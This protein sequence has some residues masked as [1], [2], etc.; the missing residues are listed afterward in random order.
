[1][2]HLTKAAVGSIV[3]RASLLTI[4]YLAAREVPYFTAIMLALFVIGWI[5]ERVELDQWH[6][7][8]TEKEQADG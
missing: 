1:M 6:R 8:K 7:Y 3:L 4:G 2:N 5:A